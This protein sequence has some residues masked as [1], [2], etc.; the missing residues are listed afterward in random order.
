MVIP[1]PVPSLVIRYSYLWQSEFLAGREDGIKDRTAAIVAAVVGEVDGR[2]RVLVLP[3]THSPPS[4][5]TT[6]IEIPAAAKRRL[7]LDEDRSWIVTV[8]A[9]EFVWPGPDLRRVPSDADGSIA[10]GYLPPGLFGRVRAAF[11]ESVEGRR[12]RGVPRTE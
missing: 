3:I 12:L 11:I 4:D 2:L 9:N 5:P 8:E 6:A 1:S 7:G 10:Y